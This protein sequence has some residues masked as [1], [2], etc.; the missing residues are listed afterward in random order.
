MNRPPRTEGHAWVRRFTLPV[1]A[2]LCLGGCGIRAEGK[3]PLARKQ[4]WEVFFNR[5]DSASVARLYSPNA[6]LVMSG[7]PPVHG[8]QA[9]GAAVAKM[10]QS[11]AKVAIETDR[12]AAAGDLAYFFGPYTVFVRHRVV[13][14]GTYLE[15]WH[16]YGGRWLIDLDVNATDAPIVPA[17]QG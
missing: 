16:R 2:V 10:V 8:R 13:E 1:L 4:L 12:S 9:I 7:A 5:G 17:P 3:P 11:G 15:V 6:E 14:R